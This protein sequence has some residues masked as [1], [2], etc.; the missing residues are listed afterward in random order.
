MEQKEKLE[1]Q[2][3][4]AKY[5]SSELKPR[6]KAAIGIQEQWEHK[7]QR[8]AA[9]KRYVLQRVSRE[10]K[11]DLQMIIDRVRRRPLLMEQTDS[12]VRARRRALF[13]VRNTL[14]TAGLKD[15]NAYFDDEEL[16]DLDQ[17][18]RW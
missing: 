10:K 8:I 13:R 2:E 4:Q 15:V 18:E 7:I 3:A 9:D 6:I 5:E 16:D 14:E 17:P 12:L 1:M 11:K